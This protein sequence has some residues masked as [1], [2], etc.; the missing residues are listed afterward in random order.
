MGVI[1]NPGDILKAETMHFRN[2]KQLWSDHILER[3]TVHCNWHTHTN[4][5]T[6]DS[7][8][9]AH[10]C[11]H[12]AAVCVHSCRHIY[13]C[14]HDT[15]LLYSMYDRLRL[16]TWHG[17]FSDTHTHTHKTAVS[18]TL[19]PLCTVC[20]CVCACFLPDISIRKVN[21]AVPPSRFSAPHKDVIRQAL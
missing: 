12:C 2:S 20:A 18:S 21:T 3:H 16:K 14:Q 10:N 11:T 6:V 15:Q 17:W 8:P 19:N 13:F 7:L 5:D 4:S 9:A 1:K